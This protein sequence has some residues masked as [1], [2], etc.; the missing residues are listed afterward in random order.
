[1]LQVHSKI[2]NISSS[3]WLWAIRSRDLSQADKKITLAKSEQVKKEI[4][5]MTTF[6]HFEGK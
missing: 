2:V 5:K 6:H 1:M 4:V 3:S